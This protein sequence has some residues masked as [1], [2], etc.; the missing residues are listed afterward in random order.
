MAQ[1]GSLIRAKG[2]HVEHRLQL[3]VLRQ[4]SSIGGKQ[5]LELFYIIV[6]YFI[7]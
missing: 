6:S 1:T 3:Q 4:R 5:C 7:L 2:D